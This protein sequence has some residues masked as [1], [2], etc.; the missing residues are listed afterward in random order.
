M[1]GRG[2]VDSILKY[3]AIGFDMDHTF[4]RYKLR[5]F[6]KHVYEAAA[7]YLSTQK[8]YPQ[9]IFPLTDADSQKTFEF[10]FRAVYDHKTG[11]LVKIGANGLIMRA[12]HGFRRLKAAEIIATYG[13]NPI[14]PGYHILAHRNA[15]FT[16]LHEYYGAAI[17]P[18]LARVVQL[19]SDGNPL[20]KD[21][22]F[23]QI[24]LDM[25]DSFDFNYAVKDEKEFL[26]GDYTGHFFPRFLSQPRHYVNKVNREFLTALRKLKDRGTITFLA[27]NSYFLVAR[28]LLLETIGPDWPDYFTFVG[29]NVKKPG[30]FE[31]RPDPPLFTDFAGTEIQDMGAWIEKPKKG[32]EK[33]VLKGHASHLSSYFEK[34]FGKDYKVLFAGDTIVSDCVYSFDKKVDKNW[35]CLLILEELMEIE[36]GLST[37]DYFAYWSEWGSA[38]MDKNIYSGVD[39]TIVFDFADNIAHR[40]FSLL[41]SR[42]CIDLFKV[43]DADLGLPK[44][45]F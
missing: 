28:I 44:A 31:T 23:K 12:F 20:L 4:V 21:V 5:N 39:N 22:S 34:K 3:N 9:D 26:N 11:N 1:I 37:K 27:S 8:K 7:I 29:F 24:I 13:K 35:D 41:E 18:L 15:D 2:K 10:F 19:K 32:E 43:S 42:E 33:V 6:V 14:I 45:P 38:L 16:N 40:A 17:V 25:F 30:W 36:Y